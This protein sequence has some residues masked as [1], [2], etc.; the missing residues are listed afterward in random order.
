[1]SETSGALQFE[2]TQD[3]RTM[4]LA[5]GLLSAFTG[6]IGPLVLFVVKKDSLFVKLCALQALLWHLIYMV[7]TML[8]MVTF[9]VGMFATIAMSAG[10]KGNAPPPFFFMFPFLWL[11]FMAG[12][13][14]NMVLGILS[15]VKA[16][17]GIWWPYPITG[18]MAKRFL[19]VNG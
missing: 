17:E 5:C 16:N 11:F 1:M 14:V 13:V 19:G 9:F 8:M 12:W 7:V 18:R 10:H 2:T 15:A 4:G 6:F 3:E